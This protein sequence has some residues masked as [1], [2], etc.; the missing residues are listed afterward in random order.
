VTV[1]QIPDTSKP[2][3]VIAI[4]VASDVRAGRVALEITVDGQQAIRISYEPHEA[5]VIA[6]NVATAAQQVA[7]GQQAPRSV[8]VI[9][10]KE[11]PPIAPR[12]K[13][14]RLGLSR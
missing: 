11:G 12:P 5:T 4:S 3:P 10:Q 14:E 2:G 6:K 7:Q 8:V 1:N 13:R 9:P